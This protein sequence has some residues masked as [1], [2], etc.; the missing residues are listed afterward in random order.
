MQRRTLLKAGLNAGLIGAAMPLGAA[1]AYPGKAFLAREVPQAL[2]EALGTA[3]IGESDNIEIEAPHIATDANLVP[4]RVRSGF[5]DTESISI[6]V[7][8]NRSPFTA[9]FRLYEP[10]TF[11]STRIRMEDSGDLLV[12]VKAGGTLHAASRPVRVGRNRCGS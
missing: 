3:D 11:V 7:A 10:Q 5:P 12:I 4:V 1:G 8:A 2:R 6:V 9:H